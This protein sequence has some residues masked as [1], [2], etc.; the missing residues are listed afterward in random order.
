M[1]QKGAESP[2]GAWQFYFGVRSVAAAKRAIEANGGKVTQG[3]HQVPG[4]DWIVNAIDPQGAVFG[5]VG[6]QGQ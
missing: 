1:M 2:F 3:P 6:P 5:L 4:G